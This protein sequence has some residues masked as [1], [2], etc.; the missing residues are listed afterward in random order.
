MRTVAPS[1]IA[2]HDQDQLVEDEKVGQETQADDH[3]NQL[4]AGALFVLKS[5][6]WPRF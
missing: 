4:D 3:Q 6:G 2:A 5:K 1:S